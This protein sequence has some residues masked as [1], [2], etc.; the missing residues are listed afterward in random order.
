M[1]SANN[2]L[3]AADFGVRDLMELALRFER[4]YAASLRRPD[5]GLACGA[6]EEEARELGFLAQSIRDMLSEGVDL[7]PLV[8]SA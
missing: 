5:D 2:S 3:D 4:A 6:E 7:D 1:N 8:L